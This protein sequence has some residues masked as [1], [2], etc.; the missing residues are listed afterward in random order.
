MNHSFAGQ[1]DNIRSLIEQGVDV[2]YLNNY[3]TS[4]LHTAAE[5][6]FAHF[7]NCFIVKKRP[8]NELI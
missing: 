8:Q 3:G 2:N 1:T 6:G 7:S 5:K 4:A